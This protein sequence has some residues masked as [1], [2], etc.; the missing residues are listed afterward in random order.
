MNLLTLEI[1]VGG[2]DNREKE[3][4]RKEK[5]VVRTL[6]YA[7]KIWIDD[8]ITPHAQR[9]AVRVINAFPCNFKFLRRT[10]IIVLK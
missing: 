3:K 4:K 10:L 5:P 7:D 1:L 9:C 8:N 2:Y 6:E